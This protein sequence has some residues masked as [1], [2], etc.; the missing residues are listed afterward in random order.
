[1]S[2]TVQTLSQPTNRS[3][4][5]QSHHLLIL[6]VALLLHATLLTIPL[7]FGSKPEQSVGLLSVTFSKLKRAAEAVTS[8][9][10]K[11][12]QHTEADPSKTIEVDQPPATV[13]PEPDLPTAQPIQE[14]PGTHLT[15]ALLLESASRREWQAPRFPATRLPQENSSGTLPRNWTDPVL[16]IFSN[17]FKDVVLPE[18]V[19][20]IDRWRDPDGT[21]Q[22]VLHT[23][24]GETI[25]GRAAPWNPMEPLVE[26]VMMMRLCGGG[27]KRKLQFTLPEPMRFE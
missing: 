23:P 18:S 12:I 27:G 3:G 7:E 16:P 5:W 25:C 13:T 17:R 24:K 10:A 6:I 9:P 2:A 8:R 15:T 20:I 11:V 19:E 4:K 21:I 1:M 26:P 22:V 14:T